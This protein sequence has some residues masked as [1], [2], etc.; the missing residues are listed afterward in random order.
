MKNRL[1]IGRG[2]SFKQDFIVSDITDGD[3]VNAN[4]SNVVVNFIFYSEDINSPIISSD[5]FTID[6]SNLRHGH[7][8]ILLSS[9]QTSLIDENLS[10]GLWVLFIEDNV[11]GNEIIT[12]GVVNFFNTDLHNLSQAGVE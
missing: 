2:E 1:Q 9:T 10:N 6:S 4:L 11:N 3:L 12:D 8:Q 5:S 7:I